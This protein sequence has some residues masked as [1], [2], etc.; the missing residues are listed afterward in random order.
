[1]LLPPMKKK[2]KSGQEVEK[3]KV[4]KAGPSKVKVEKEMQVQ[5]EEEEEEELVEVKEECPGSG[6]SHT[7]HSP[8]TTINA[9]ID[10]ASSSWTKPIKD[11]QSTDG[12]AKKA[13][14]GKNKEPMKDIVKRLKAEMEAKAKANRSKVKKEK[15][16]E[17]DGQ[18]RPAR[19]RDKSVDLFLRLIIS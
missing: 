1:M 14:G 2:R 10:P 19:F 4:V 7:H 11:D 8:S 15:R 6:H 3:E 12:T 5:L 16:V 13:N 17:P 9:L 18:V